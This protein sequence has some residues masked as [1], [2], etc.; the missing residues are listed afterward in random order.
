MPC[1]T[2]WGTP[3]GEACGLLRLLRRRGT[4]EKAALSF[5]LPVSEVREALDELEAAG[6]LD[7]QGG[8][9]RTNA[10]GRAIAC[11]PP[12]VDPVC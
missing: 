1:W 3:T 4:P 8:T 11:A 6:L 9:Y 2:A 5:G 12:A 7:R 10:R